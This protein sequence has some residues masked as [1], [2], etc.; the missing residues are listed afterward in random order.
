L[1]KQRV[2][3]ETHNYEESTEKEQDDEF[4]AD[5]AASYD[6]NFDNDIAQSATEQLETTSAETHTYSLEGNGI[7]DPRITTDSDLSVDFSN[8]DDD[9]DDNDETDS[10]TNV[11]RGK[12]DSN[13]S[14]QLDEADKLTET[15]LMGDQDDLNQIETNIET[16]DEDLETTN[17][18]ADFAQ[19]VNFNISADVEFTS[20]G[21]SLT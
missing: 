6:N 16:S 13:T 4:S 17:L 19:P 5:T 14:E 7:V 9:D 10:S 18:S 1:K 3:D 8:I 2:P 21:G 12:S 15:D 20:L 11:G